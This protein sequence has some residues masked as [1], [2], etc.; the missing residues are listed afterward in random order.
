MLACST[1]VG[2]SPSC[3]P[4]A[5]GDNRLMG[6][7]EQHADKWEPV[8]TGCL[9]WTGGVGS[10]G[11]PMVGIF[12]NKTA[13]VSRLVCEETHGSPPTPKHRAIHST[14]TGCLGGLCV[15]GHHL[16]WGTAKDNALDEPPARRR[17]W[18]QRGYEAKTPESRTRM[19][20]KRFEAKEAGEEIYFSSK[21][22][23]RG[24]TGPR[25]IK[26]DCIECV[27]YRNSLR[28]RK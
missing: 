4:R 20:K 14:P 21:P 16:R 13:L 28:Y 18:S 15:S 5:R 8:M 12:G 6:V 1:S 22:C 9:I 7:L 10:H 2:G 11:R 19:R 26:G 24:H 25:R 27:N 3:R 23:K 17:E